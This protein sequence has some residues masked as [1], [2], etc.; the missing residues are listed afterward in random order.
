MIES[1]FRVA[2]RDAV[3]RQSR[4]PFYWGGLKGYQQLQA[5]SKALHNLQTTESLYFRRLICQVDRTL[6]K[7]HRLAE[8]LEIAHTWLRR[9]A[10]CLRYPPSSHTAVNVTPE[11]VKQ[12][13]QT[14]LLQFAAE[15]SGKTVP[16]ALYSGLQRRWRLV[17]QDLLHCYVIPGLPPDNLQLESLFG[18]LRCHQRRISGRKSTKQL[19]DFGHYQVLFMA[20][21]EEQ[22]LQS[23]QYVPVRDYVKQRTF[24]AQ[25]EAT[26]QFL[27]R[28]H[29][30]P[31]KTMTHL[32]QMYSDRC[33]HAPQVAW[34]V[35]LQE[36]PHT[37]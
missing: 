3:N 4:K 22:L 13:V 17:G 11:Q 26:R 1:Q 33:I 30:D 32:A 19:R 16:M 6:E 20:E 37:D 9:F 5:I 10:D 15:A 35:I 21:S 31:A 27:Y 7:N 29:R 34:P 36:Y 8:E 2:I 24:L 25:A 18:H 12:E 23:I 28:L 14:L